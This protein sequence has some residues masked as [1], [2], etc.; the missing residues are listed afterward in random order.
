MTPS[1]PTVI[2]KPSLGVVVLVRVPGA[3]GTIYLYIDTHAYYTPETHSNY[4]S[5]YLT[6]NPEP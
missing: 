3:G 4:I 2:L 6:Q 1:N 5:P